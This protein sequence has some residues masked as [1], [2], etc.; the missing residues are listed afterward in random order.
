MNVKDAMRGAAVN[1]YRYSIL[2]NLC[3]LMLL[4]HLIACGW[5]AFGHLFGNANGWSVV[6]NVEGKG[7]L[8]SI[9]AVLLLDS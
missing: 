5:W 3:L 9:W 8:Y 1:V 6:Y 4:N 2:L 7:L